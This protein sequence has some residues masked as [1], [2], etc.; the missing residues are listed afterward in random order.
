MPAGKQRRGDG[1][2]A[3]HEGYRAAQVDEAQ[4]V[5]ML[6]ADA[7][8]DHGDGHV[9]RAE[10]AGGPG[11]LRADGAEMPLPREVER[12][13]RRERAH[14]L[15]H[16]VVGDRRRAEVHLDLEVR[17][18]LRRPGIHGEDRGVGE[19]GDDREARVVMTRLDDRA[20]GSHL[21]GEGS[22]NAV[23]ETDDVTAGGEGIR[24]DH[25]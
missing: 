16:E 15:G 19:S 12:G 17:E 25:E 10:T 14:R 5:G 24:R 18:D 8:V 21:V 1:I 9:R 22:G 6:V 7:G 13:L 2:V 23:L 11:V 3:R 4:Q 20:G